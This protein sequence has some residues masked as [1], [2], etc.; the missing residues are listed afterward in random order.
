MSV[1]PATQPP[2]LP[3]GSAPPAPAVPGVTMPFAIG[4]VV[5]TA[6]ETADVTTLRIAVDDVRICSG[7]PGQFVMAALLG[8]PPSA[9]SIS[10]Y[11]PDG[12]EL[13]VRAAGPATA[14]LRAVRPGDS[15][16]LRGPL[17]RPWPLALAAERDLVVVAGGIGLAPLRPVI[18]AVTAAPDRYQR[19]HL[20]YG[21]KTPSDRI[22]VAETFRY[23]RCRCVDVAETVDR[24]DDDW[25][26][27]VG[28]V[29]CLL[30]EE[31]WDRDRLIAFICGPERMMQVVGETLIRQGV[32][33][34][35]IYMTLERHMECGIGLCGH[36]QVGRF[37]VC[38]DGPVFSMA[39][40]EGTFGREGI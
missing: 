17:G 25:M 37:F 1:V 19:L 28:L 21:A 18:D 31:G 33:K 14:A 2:A 8:F 15:V 40:L 36:C 23:R 16:G 9:I 34:D 29:T 26:G 35:R 10:R 4:T 12:I 22:F 30:E 24:P 32:T 13:T 27:K 3:R 38:R 11:H 20:C 7:A 6:P 39:E 5:W